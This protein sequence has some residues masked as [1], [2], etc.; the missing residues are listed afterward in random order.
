[1]GAREHQLQPL[2]GDRVVA[3]AA[4]GGLLGCAEQ[5][6]PVALADP[7]PA[8]LV[9]QS[10]AC[11]HQEPC[12]GHPGN[13][14]GG[15]VHERRGE[16]VREG[17]LRHGHVVRPAGE[18][19]EQAPIAFARYPLRLDPGPGQ[20]VICH[21]GRTSTAPW[22]APGQRAAQSIAASRSFASTM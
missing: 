3:D 10:P 12:F 17:V 22:A 14:R 1:V 19:G 21:S 6:L 9:R 20:A 4:G 2:V 16:G 11:G 5:L 7:A 15:P 13:A 8:G 18:K